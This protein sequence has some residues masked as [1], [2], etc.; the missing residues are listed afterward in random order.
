MARFVFH[1]FTAISLIFFLA[2]CG[3]WIGNIRS[4]GVAYFPVSPGHDQFA[5][6]SEFG[7]LEL[8]IKENVPIAHPFVDWWDPLPKGWGI[9]QFKEGWRWH[10][11]YGFGRMT[12]MVDDDSSVHPP[13]VVP[14]TEYLIPDW[15]LI[16]IFAILPA[17]SLLFR[18]R[19]RHRIRSGCCPVCGYDLRATPD[20]CPECG[21]SPNPPSR[22]A[23]STN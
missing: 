18:L 1:L 4:H 9:D 13:I 19:F 20:R 16:A 5:I 15:F 12:G 11:S 2:I 21:T 3:L 6:F 7:S 23:E 10:S 14:M 22:L 17:I 8:L